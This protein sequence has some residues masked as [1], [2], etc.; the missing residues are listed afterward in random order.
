MKHVCI[1]KGKT[2]KDDNEVFEELGEC[3]L[4][5][6]LEAWIGLYSGAEEM[7]KFILGHGRK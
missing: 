6:D 4:H 1:F 2:I 7:G 3:V 5:R